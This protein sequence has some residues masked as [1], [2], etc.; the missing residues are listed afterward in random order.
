MEELFSKVLEDDEKIV[1]VFKPHKGKLFLS[2]LLLNSIWLFFVALMCV[3][4]I[5]FPEEG[6]YVNPI[7]VLVPIGA[8]VFIISI[9]ALITNIYYNNLFYAYSNKRVIVRT[10]IFGVDYKSLDI[11]MI[12]AVDVYV[13]LFDKIIR[14]NTGSITFGSAAAPVINGAASTYKFNHIVMPYETCKEIKNYIAE[15]KK[16][17]K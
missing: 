4:A 8:Y 3:L 13:S 2:S 6:D 17:N 10:G 11:S 1:K 15:Q 9:I 12:G 16:L 7:L 5:L 14:K